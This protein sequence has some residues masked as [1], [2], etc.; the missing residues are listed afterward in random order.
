MKKHF[1]GFLYGAPIYI[2][3][4]DEEVAA[5]AKRY[6]FGQPTEEERKKSL[7]LEIDAFCYRANR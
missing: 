3:T 2:E 1:L 7:E 4:D 6:R 5:A